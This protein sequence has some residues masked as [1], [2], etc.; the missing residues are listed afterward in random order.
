MGTTQSKAGSDLIP[1]PSVCCTPFTDIQ[2]ADSVESTESMK[3]SESSFRPACRTR[4]RACR[5]PCAR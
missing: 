4:S 2:R 1:T 5:A 3:R